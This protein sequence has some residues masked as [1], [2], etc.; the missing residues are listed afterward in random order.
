M[1][2][3][4]VY[5]YLT[6]AIEIWGNA[7]DN[8]IN[9]VISL[10]KRIVRII[11]NKNKRQEDF[12]FPESEPLFRRLKIMEFKKIFQFKVLIFVYKCLTKQTPINFADWFKFVS[13]MQGLKT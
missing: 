2:Y 7:S 12:A 11:C 10:Q 8:Q 13:D 5:P 1:Y 6:Y 3:S 4:L 9:R